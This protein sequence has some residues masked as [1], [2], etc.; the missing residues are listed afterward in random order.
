MSIQGWKYYNHAMIPECPPNRNVDIS[1]VKSG[2]IWSDVCGRGTP[3]LAQWTSDWDCGYGTNWWYI[4]KD[5]PL[6][7][8]QLKAKRRYEINKG[9]KFFEVKQIHPQEYAEKL[10]LVQ[11]AAF[12]AYPEKYR[13]HVEK[14]SFVQEVEHWDDTAVFGA[15]YRNNN[16]LAGY[17]RVNKTDEFWLEFNVLKTKPEFEKNAVNAAI[18]AEI[19]TFF[20]PFLKKGG[21]ICDGSR[22]INHETHFQDYLEKYFGFRKVFCRLHIAYNPKIVWAIPILYRM[23]N[24]FAKLDSVGVVHQINVVLKM[25]EIVRSQK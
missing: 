15:F 12:S 22:S 4:I 1:A 16:E 3:L 17:A 2:K 18:V 8:S 11:V 5:T 25:E 9:M 6:D 21:S 23:R 19:L 13:P 10:Y 14:D 7:I 24:L 20:E